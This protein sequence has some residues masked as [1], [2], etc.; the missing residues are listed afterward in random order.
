MRKFT[1]S[2]MLALA[3][4]AANAQEPASKAWSD[5]LTTTM[6]ALDL[7]RGADM[8]I[9]NEGNAIVTGSYTDA[10]EFANSYLEPIATS[11]FVAK[12][13][14]EGKKKWA[15]GLKGAATITTVTTDAEGNVYAAGVFADNVF[16]LDGNGVSKNTITGMKDNTEQKSGF[17]VKYNKEGEYVASKVI[18]PEQ[19]RTDELYGDPDPSFTPSKIVAA[20]GEVYIATS[21]QGDS[22]ISD[23]LTLKG[24]YGSIVGAFTWDVPTLAIISMSDDFSNAELVAQLAST[25]N[26]TSIGYGAE[27]LNFTIDGSK[28]YAGFVA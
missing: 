14:K 17:I 11:A 10:I 5:N 22:K 26:E 20:N 2:V 9:D 1:L 6:E 27:S 3:A 8:A 15:A 21:F 23:G 13:D 25:A 12:Y 16:I 18:I 7:R 19:A 24:Q 4:M 28:V